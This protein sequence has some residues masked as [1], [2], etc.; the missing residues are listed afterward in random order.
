MI[1]IT[2]ANGKIGCELVRILAPRP[3]PVRA[4]VRSRLRAAG[5]EG[6]GVPLVVGDFAR[7][8]TLAPLLEG[9][10]RVFLVS[11]TSPRVAELHGA[12]LE[13]AK[14]C[15]VEHVVRVST[16]GAAPD[17]ATSMQ[18]WHGEAE[19]VLEGS[20]IAYTHL[21]PAYFMQSTRAFAPL[22]AARGTI[23]VPAGDGR[24]GMVDL[25]DVAAAGAA[26]LTAADRAVH[27][28]AGYDLTGPETLSLADV[29]A[30]LSAATDRAIRYVDTPP[31]RAREVMVRGGLEPW[32]ADAVVEFY[33]HAATG[34]FELLTGDVERLLGRPPRDF[35]RFAREHAAYFRGDETGS[36]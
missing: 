29:A 36:E 11:S 22:T 24:I 27:R 17:A 18:R 30:R 7:R 12:L 31:D 10:D 1:L 14:A 3:E 28:G 16:I 34:A 13:A 9:V 19:A 5:V 33:R 21:R 32:L 4:M 15:G 8:Q 25:R 20:G 35:D 26:V 2:G 6:L 23:T